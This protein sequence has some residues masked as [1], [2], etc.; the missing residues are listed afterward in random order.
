[1][2]AL[3]GVGFGLAQL[4]VVQRVETALPALALLG[5]AGSVAWGIGLTALQSATD[6]AY[7][8]RVMGVYVAIQPTFSAAGGWAFALLAQVI[9][10]PAALGVAGTILAAGSVAYGLKARLAVESTH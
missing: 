7:A 3:A 10:T 9:S 8:G 4:A 6:P 1:M 5:I 2:A